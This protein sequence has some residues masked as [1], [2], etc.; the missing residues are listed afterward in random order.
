[1]Q[2]GSEILLEGAY[3]KNDE[4]VMYAF[5]VNQTGTDSVII[6]RQ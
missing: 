3:H 6:R 5:V 4:Q 1:M 2:D